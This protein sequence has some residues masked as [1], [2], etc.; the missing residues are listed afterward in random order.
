[1]SADDPWVIEGQRSAAHALAAVLAEKVEI[2]LVSMVTLSC[3]NVDP[4]TFCAM[5]A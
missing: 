1:M 2:G 3:G 4:A 5:L